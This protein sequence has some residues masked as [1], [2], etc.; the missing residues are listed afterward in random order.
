M[1][2][3]TLFILLIL[4]MLSC[5][6]DEAEVGD[7]YEYH[8]HIMSPNSDHK[9]LG[10]ELPIVIDFESHTG[11]PVHHINVSIYR[12]S[13][14]ST[15]YSKPEEAHIHETSGEYTFMD[16]LLLDASNGI[17]V[18]NVYVLE[19]KVWGHED[20]VEEEISTVEFQVQP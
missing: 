19:A 15:M 12:K 14:G 7:I 5:K 11:Q 13:D 17:T 16:S 8:A 6:K 1:Q 18:N 10:D 2:N 3:N 9:H 20:G 4:S